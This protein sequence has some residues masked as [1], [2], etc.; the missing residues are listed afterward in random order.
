MFSG[1]IKNTGVVVDSFHEGSNKTFWIKSEMA[2]EL[3]VDQSISHNGVCL[4]VEEIKE[5]RYRVTAIE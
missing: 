4:T 3:H 1:I 5:D 2:A